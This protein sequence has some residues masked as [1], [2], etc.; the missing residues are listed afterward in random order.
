ML[1]NTQTLASKTGPGVRKEPPKEGLAILSQGGCRWTLCPR[2]ILRTGKDRGLHRAA[3]PR[4]ISIIKRTVEAAI[5]F[6]RLVHSTSAACETSVWTK[7]ASPP[8]A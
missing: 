4:I 1:L 7:I 3:N 8:A 5:R 2:P 6:D